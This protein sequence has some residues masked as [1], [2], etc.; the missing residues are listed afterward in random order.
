MEILFIQIQGSKEIIGALVYSIIFLVLLTTGLLLFFH[1]S[2]R[3]LVQKELEKIQLKLTHQKQILQATIT[4][5]EDERRRIAQ[6][7][8]DSISAKLNVI[9]LTTNMLL[10]EQTLHKDHIASLQ[11]ILNVTTSTL[12]SARKIAHDLLPPILDKFGLKVALEELF[13]DF[14]KASQLQIVYDIEDIES[15]SKTEQLHIFRITQELINNATR[16]GNATSL[17]I[18]L[19]KISNGFKLECSDNGIGFEVT[20]ISKNTGLGLQNI[21]SRASILG[22]ELIIKSALSQGSTFILKSIRNE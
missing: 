9:S 19:D 20:E 1:Y 5:Q 2:R 17:K 12:E 7:L 3:K 15:L 16:H 18:K 14:T 6:D 11:H 21:K 22:C 13:E 4:T 10:D 8:H